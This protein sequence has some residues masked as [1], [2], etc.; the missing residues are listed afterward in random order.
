MLANIPVTGRPVVTPED[1]ANGPVVTTAKLI[2]L[3]CYTTDAE[4]TAGGTV[5]G[6]VMMMFPT[7]IS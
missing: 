2:R 1:T 5:E 4:G 7:Y 3:S 6:A